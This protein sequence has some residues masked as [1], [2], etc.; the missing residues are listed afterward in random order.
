MTTVSND[1]LI[2]HTI[3]TID[4]IDTI[5]PYTH[6][7]V[8]KNDGICQNIR[9]KTNSTER[10]K[11]TAT[12]ENFCGYHYKNP[13]SFF[14]NKTDDKINN[15]KKHRPAKKAKLE[16]TIDYSADEYKKAG[17]SIVKWVKLRYRLRSILRQGPAR[18]ERTIATNANDF[19]SY[20]PIEEISGVQLFSYLD[21]NDKQIY[22]CDIRSIHSLI[23]YAKIEGEKPQNPY[24]RNIID[25]S[26]IKKVHKHVEYC[27]KIG[28]SSEYEPLR[29]PTPEQSFRMKVVDVFNTINELN[30]YSSPE[31]F[32]VL[33]LNKQKRFY[34]ELYELWNIRAGL[35]TVQK[36]TIVPGYHGK[37]F[38][39]TIHYINNMST[40]EDVRKHN[41]NH[42]KSLISSARLEGDRST[43]AMYVLTALTVVSNQ[44]RI[45]YP[46]LFESINEGD[47]GVGAGVGAGVG[48]GIA[49]GGAA[50]AGAG[51]AGG[52][53]AGGAGPLNILHQGP[54]FFEALLLQ[55]MGGG[56]MVGD[57]AIP[58]FNLQD[59]ID[60][61]D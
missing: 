42:I 3:D 61:L 29:P 35:T 28:C 5:K 48:V 31:W 18:F 12:H 49:A 10:C 20:A 9:S 24:T 46:W 6:K 2:S 27:M 41:L 25:F 39:H 16:K 23:H 11:N 1:S 33:D 54:G 36:N 26:I 57:G 53:A 44:A 7:D 55:L 56:G 21:H 19:F 60:A 30:Y 43:G 4:T 13:K 32:L 22:I 45:A 58:Q 8:V 34:R 38:R 37:I 52:G 17:E 51:T 40:L 50:G 14:A 59:D 15:K 47:V